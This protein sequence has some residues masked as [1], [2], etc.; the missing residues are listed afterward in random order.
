MLFR[1]NRVSEQNWGDNNWCPIKWHRIH[2][3]Y[4]HTVRSSRWRSTLRE[5]CNDFVD[6]SALR[7]ETVLS[8]NVWRQGCPSQPANQRRYRYSGNQAVAL[9]YT[10]RYHP[11][12]S[13][14]SFKKQM[15]YP[16]L[17]SKRSCRYRWRLEMEAKKCPKTPKKLFVSSGWHAQLLA[18]CCSAVVLLNKYNRK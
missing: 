17:L 11:F 15:W 16:L 5:C 2:D 9:H 6:I 1:L 4:K 12:H 18:R 14:Y 7:L 13:L 8:P 10:T 3:E